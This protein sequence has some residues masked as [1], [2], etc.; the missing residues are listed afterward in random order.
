MGR[1]LADKPY[2]NWAT[3]NMIYFDHAVSIAEDMGYSNHAYV[4]SDKMLLSAYRKAIEKLK[5]V[6]RPCFVQQYF[7]LE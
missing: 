1:I 4:P 6:D 5:D 3:A 7:G 2:Y